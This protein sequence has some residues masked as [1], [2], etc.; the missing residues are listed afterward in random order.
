MSGFNSRCTGSISVCNQPPRPTQP[1]HP[2]ASKRNDYQPKGDDW[3]VKAR[4]VCM[5]V[6]GKTVGTICKVAN[7]KFT[8]RH[9]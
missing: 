8:E 1:G 7:S 2:F 6:A 4:M 9:E 5:W 3:G